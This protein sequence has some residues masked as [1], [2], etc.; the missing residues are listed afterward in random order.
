LL[1]RHGGSV[2]V[3]SPGEGLGTT[4][5]IA[6]PA[7]PAGVGVEGDA[8]GAR[9]DGVRILVVDDDRDV[10][11]GLRAVLEDRGALVLLATSASD[12]RGHLAAA[13]PD[14][15]VS[16]IRLPGEDGYALL[17]AV[18]AG[19]SVPAVAIT[20]YEAEETSE[21]ALAA[22]FHAHFAKPFDPDA[23]IG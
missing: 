7:L 20:A 22:G 3:D 13:R 18:R 12:A 16:D 5:T 11:E 1:Y 23:L 14:V 21:R 15:L 2:V 10:R 17:R 8:D 9:L 19:K 6:L 4:V